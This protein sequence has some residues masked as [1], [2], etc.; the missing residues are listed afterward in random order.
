MLLKRTGLIE[1]FSVKN[2]STHNPKRS[3]N[4]RGSCSHGNRK[5]AKRTQ[6]WMPSPTKHC[7][8]SNEVIIYKHF[9]SVKFQLPDCDL[10]CFN[11]ISSSITIFIVCVCVCVCVRE[12]ERDRGR[13]MNVYINSHMTCQIVSAFTS[14]NTSIKGSSPVLPKPVLKDPLACTCCMS[15]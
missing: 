9:K 12:R 13:H 7:E 1:Q 3:A 10:Q 14:I 8:W 2:Y 5:S 11:G 6:Q 4:Q 15:P